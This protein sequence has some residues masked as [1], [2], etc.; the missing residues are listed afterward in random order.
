MTSTGTDRC[1]LLRGV[2]VEQGIQ[3]RIGCGERIIG[4]Q[5]RTRQPTHAAM[6]EQGAQP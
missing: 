5:F 2:H 3:L 1:E 4:Q 6:V